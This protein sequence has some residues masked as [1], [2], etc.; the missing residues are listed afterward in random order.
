[1]GYRLVVFRVEALAFRVYALKAFFG[2]NVEQRACNLFYVRAAA[3][4]ECQ[5]RRVQDRE[6][7]FYKRGVGIFDYLPL[8]TVN[9]FAVVVKL[10][11][12]AEQGLEVLVALARQFTRRG[13]QR[14]LA[15][16]LL[17]IYLVRRAICVLAAF[18]CH[19]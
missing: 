10:G 4:G 7:F 13:Q 12:E 2:K 17:A 3:M 15:T 19:A 18:T 6:Q 14:V 8:L 16:A 5:V 9:A 1:V 11:L